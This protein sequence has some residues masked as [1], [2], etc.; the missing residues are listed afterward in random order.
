MLRRFE[1]EAQAT[2]AL[3]ST[4]TITLYDF[5]ITE[6]GHFYYAMELLQ[7]LDLKS[8]VKRFGPIPSNRTIFLLKQVCHSLGDAHHHGL[9][10][11]DIKPANI[12]VSRLGPD[13]DFVKVLDFGLVKSHDTSV[14]GATQLTLKGVTTGT[15]AYIASE[16]VL[17]KEGI[18]SRADLY[19]LGCVAYWL[20]TGQLVFEGKNPME[21]LVHH[22]QSEPTPPSQRSEFEIPPLDELILCCLA[23][24]SHRWDLK[25][26]P[27]LV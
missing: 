27:C 5:G 20:L 23:A 25:R 21:V 2:A 26:P 7:G 9:V 6:D 3:R 22:V 13:Y 18:D 11:R 15:P 19:A 14:E 24:I 10:H 8:M 12:Y 17:G 1:R 16:M 4:H